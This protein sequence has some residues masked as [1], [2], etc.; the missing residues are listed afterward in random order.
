M[1]TYE[2]GYQAGQYARYD[3]SGEY[4]DGVIVDSFVALVAQKQ[5]AWTQL[6]GAGQDAFL[7]GFR[8]GWA[9]GPITG[10]ICSV[11]QGRDNRH[12][13]TCKLVR[14]CEN[15]ACPYTTTAYY[16]FC[17]WECKHDTTEHDGSVYSW[18]LRA[19]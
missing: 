10:Q 12:Y 14:P 9:A 4:T 15:P 18:G 2:Q 6:D 8:Q 5:P 17:S 13:I 16:R 19:A 1:N 11:C 3:F 7:T